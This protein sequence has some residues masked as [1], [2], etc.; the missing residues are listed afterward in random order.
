M[1]R[2]SHP[3]PDPTPLSPDRQLLEQIRLRM[4]LLDV[5]PNALGVALEGRCERTTLYRYLRDGSGMRARHLAAVLDALDL[6][7]LPRPR[8]R[9][10]GL[11]FDR[12]R[13]G[14]RCRSA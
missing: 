4:E 14:G 7:V 2:S 1:P 6:E 11:A 5:S 12:S 10:T 9:E 3:V 13:A 8:G